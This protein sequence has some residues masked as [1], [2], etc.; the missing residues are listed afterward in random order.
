[1]PASFVTEPP[2]RRQR[3]FIVI[4]AF[5]LA[6]IASVAMIWADEPLLHL[7]AFMP[8]YAGIVIVTDLLTAYLMAT[9]FRIAAKPSI[10]L[11]SSA[12]LFSSLIVVPH[13]LLFPGVVSET[14]L[15]GAG[16]Q[17]AIW[18][19]VFWHGGFP[20]LI[21]AYAG[22]RYYETKHPIQV[23]V[24]KYLSLVAPMVI[25]FLVLGLTLLVTFGKEVLPVLVRGD[26]F[27]SLSQS[28]F[29]ISV[30]FF[31][32]L[33]LMAVAG[34]TRGRTVGELGLVL[35]MLASLLD[36]MLTLHSS[37][38]FSLGW[39]VSR[40][41]S[42]VSSGVVLAVYIYEV[43]W[44]YQRVAELNENLSRLA[45]VDQLTSLANRRQFDQRLE[46][47][48]NRAVRD[49]Q[50]L[51]L[52]IVDV[53]F[54]KKF[55]DRYGHLPG[56]DCLRQVAQAILGAT[57]RPGDLAARYG[58][59]EFALILPATSE[60]GATRVAEAVN[61]SVRRL[62]IRHEDGVECGVVTISVGVAV[63]RPTLGQGFEALKEAADAAL[64]RAKNAGRNRNVVVSC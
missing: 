31:N 17:S 37:A 23:R 14:G 43:N 32:M 16:L 39:Y 24:E 55:N 30:V 44:L 48:W 19:W 58:G 10:L 13:M 12:Y 26:D 27:S 3:V 29:S 64:Y 52:A 53:D 61:E 50:P 49:Q 36:V 28:W 62:S 6:V 41:N 54:F 38:R 33:A 63:V 35:A 11:L 7:S 57:R 9:Q 20:L 1:M 40:M 51:S 22:L 21:L 4:S 60:K 15:L 5:L 59:E 47:E 56:D 18:M 42:V 45:F 34:V 25:A 8:F 46:V 2:S